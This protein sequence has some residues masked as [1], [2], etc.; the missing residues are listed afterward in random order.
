M[1]DLPRMLKS[2]K[3][4]RRERG[5]S[6][7]FGS[8][9]EFLRW[10]DEVLPLL[11]FEDKL[12]AEF[13]HLVDAATSVETWR[14]QRYAPNINNAVGCVTRAITLLEHADKTPVPLPTASSEASPLTADAKVTLKWLFE[15]ATWPVYATFLG[16]LAVS[17]GIGREVGKFETQIQSSSLSKPAPITT[18]PTNTIN[19]SSEPMK[20]EV[21]SHTASSPK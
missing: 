13:K 11:E 15:H 7:P 6:S 9:T 10:S 18:T 5:N 21:K 4:L 1:H 20:P 14:P 17:F 16:S 2:L 3:A 8:H 12:A 19:N